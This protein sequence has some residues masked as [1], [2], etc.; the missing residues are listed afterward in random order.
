LYAFSSVRAS[1]IPCDI[2]GGLSEM[3][4]LIDFWPLNDSVGIFAK[5]FKM[6]DILGWV[7]NPFF[8]LKIQKEIFQK[9]LPS[10]LVLKFC[11]RPFL[12]IFRNGG[13]IQ[14]GEFL[15]FYFQKFSKNEM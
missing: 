5:K 2:D 4:F 12:K 9:I 15:T 7:K 13:T 14:D 3:T 11:R 8:S 1:V 10:F 6:A